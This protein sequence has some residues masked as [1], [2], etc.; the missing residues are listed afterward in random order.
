MTDP[1]SDELAEAECTCTQGPDYEGPCSWCD[2][3]G[4]PSVAHRHGVDAGYQEAKFSYELDAAASTRGIQEA[5]AERDALQ[6]RVQQL[7]AAYTD[8]EA[9]RPPDVLRAR[10][11]ELTAALTELVALQDEPHPHGHTNEECYAWQD[12]SAR[13]DNA[14]WAR[15][16]ELTAGAT[17]TGKTHDV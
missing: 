3:H 2:V 1:R 5:R 14:A 6:A 13:R 10:V 11:E 4:Q 9:H 8:L 12:D 7:T 16:R 15:A 17:P